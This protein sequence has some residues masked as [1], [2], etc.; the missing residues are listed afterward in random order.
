MTGLHR[1]PK[2]ILNW[3]P[4]A[5]A[6]VGA[7]L[8]HDGRYSCSVDNC[9]WSATDPKHPHAIEQWGDQWRRAASREAAP[10]A[11]I[12]DQWQ[13]IYRC[14]DNSIS[15]ISK[16]SALK[17]S[18][19]NIFGAADHASIGIGYPRANGDEYHL[20]A[21]RLLAKHAS[22]LCELVSH[23]HISVLPKVHTTQV[24]MTIRSLSHH[25]ALWNPSEVVPHWYALPSGAIPKNAELNEIN[26][27]LIPFPYSVSEKAFSPHTASN[28]CGRAR[29]LPEFGFFEYSP[30]HAD[31]WISNELKDIIESAAVKCPL[32]GVIMP[33]A[34]L[35]SSSSFD[36]AYRQVSAIAP[37]AFFLAGVNESDS[38]SKLS[39]NC[40]QYALPMGTDYAIKFTQDKHHRWKIDASQIIQYGLSKKLDQ[41]KQW[42]EASKLTGRELNI[43][44]LRE[45]FTCCFLICEDLARQEPI[46]PLLRTVGP[47]LIVALLSDGPQLRNRWPGRY[48]TVLAEDP[49]SAVLSLTSL[50]MC[51]LSKPSSSIARPDV[52]SRVVAL[53]RD[54]RK[55][56][57]LELPCDKRGL[58]LQLRGER[59]TEFS[60]DGRRNSGASD[61][62]L[63]DLTRV[64]AV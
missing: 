4:D 60:A 55:S 24:G 7:L 51:L 48:A 56:H 54:K 28:Q 20:K 62:F 10:P 38:N 29:M 33:E 36:S 64:V 25:L 45:W 9:A 2:Q 40:V 6:I 1:I 34:S 37:A 22:S 31:D 35:S 57:E 23:T 19:L 63:D 41:G 30:P 21:L 59:Q 12:R 17:R 61:L 16:S 14:L 44:S 50:G 18:L 32:H 3:P 8:Q 39:R 27:L 53:W 13:T 42:W 58:I 43:F 11:A 49:G 52:P 5:F 46:A 15:S 47:N 26:L